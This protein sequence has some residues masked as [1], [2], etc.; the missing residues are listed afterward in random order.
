MGPDMSVCVATYRRHAA[1]NLASLAQQLGSA[2]GDLSV[3][4]V[5]VLNGISARAAGVPAWATIVDLG[6]NRGV[7][8][9][10][11]R[12]GLAATGA[13]LVFA[14]DDVALGARSLSLLNEALKRE[15]DAGVVGPVGTR[16]DLVAARHLAYLKP[17]SLPVG[18][19][20]DCDVVSGFLFATPAELWRRVGGFDEAYTP[21]GFEEVDYCTAVRLGMG[22]RCLAV[23]GVCV[24]HD[25]G[26]SARRSWRRVR[27]Q[28]R[29][30]RL[31]SVA[32]R[33]RA[34]FMRKWRVAALESTR[35]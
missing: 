32:Q 24:Q 27:W 17:T 8:V 34:H 1:P 13:A 9:A 18:S 30:E 20:R 28:G 15:A 11:N 35:A 22:K 25:F 6:V 7:P 16:W 10:W 4:L 3:E 31:G 29:S 2:A 5:V 21:C 23:E 26:V 33:N 12:A 19:V 14:N